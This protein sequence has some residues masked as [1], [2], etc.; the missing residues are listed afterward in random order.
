[1]TA[2][3]ETAIVGAGQVG[4][5]VG[6]ALRQADPAF[7]VTSVSLYDSDPEVA[8]ES[9]ALGAGDRVLSSPE[10]VL[11]ASTVVLAIPLGE[12]LSW[13]GQFGHRL[14]PG[15]T[16][17]DTGSAKVAVVEAMA[18]LVPEGVRAI[19]GHPLAGSEIPGPGGAAPGALR[20][21]TFA[22]CPCREDAEAI[23]RGVSLASACTARP[24]IMSASDHDRLVARTSH[25]PHLVAS[26]CA[27]SLAVLAG[28]QPLLR[29]LVGS[30]FRSV[31]RLAASDPRMVAEFASAN[32]GALEAALADFRVELERLTRALTAGPEA[33]AAELARGRQVRAGLLEGV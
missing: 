23:A 28:E 30:G 2:L 5:T 15:T 14:R 19:G 24:V 22:L 32:R 29:D 27:A 6:L 31:S 26:A 21:A 18:Q 10:G 16:L 20:G 11:A 17:L 12:I 33:L 7:E 13:L 4:T 1:M 3:G 25:L 8:A 9:L